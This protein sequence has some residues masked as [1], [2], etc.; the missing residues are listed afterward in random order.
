MT[1]N[2]D[3]I[4]ARTTQ[5]LPADVLLPGQEADAGAM[6]LEYEREQA[7]RV[8]R[9]VL[10]CDRTYVRRQVDDTAIILLNEMRKA[11]PCTAKHLAERLSIST[12]KSAN[13]IKSLTV[14][15]LAEKVCITRR[16]VVQEDNLPY[17]VGHRERNDC[18]VYRAYEQ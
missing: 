16:S 17:R 12:H 13:L 1:N 6:M 3:L 14:A 11:G 10:P 5:R 18:W 8:R 7:K 9:Q 2:T 15:G 4:L